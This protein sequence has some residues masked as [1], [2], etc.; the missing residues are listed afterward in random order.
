MAVAAVIIVGYV[1]SFSFALWNSLHCVSGVLQCER[2]LS[3]VSV[4]W[5]CL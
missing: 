5:S 4:D 2:S 3:Y 1:L